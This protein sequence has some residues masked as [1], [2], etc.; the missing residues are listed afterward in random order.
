MGI[1]FTKGVN[2]DGGN[3]TADSLVTDVGGA[4]SGGNRCGPA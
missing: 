1:G 2:R 3:A 4:I